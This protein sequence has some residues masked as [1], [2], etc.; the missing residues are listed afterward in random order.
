KTAPRSARSCQTSCHVQPYLLRDRHAS[1]LKER[2]A[3][4]FRSF[5]GFLAA[6]VIVAV[7]AITRA[8]QAPRAAVMTP[9]LWEITVQ[10]KSPILG[11]P[12]THTVCIAKAIVPPPAPPKSKASSDCRVQSDAAASN[13]TAYTIRCAQAGTTSSWRFTYSGDHFDGTATIA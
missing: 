9:G 12:T 3:M 5:L 6:F 13:E 10:T 11:P 2:S 7:A 4:R 1:R 8:Q